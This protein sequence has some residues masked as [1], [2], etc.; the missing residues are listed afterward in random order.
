MRETCNAKHILDT[1]EN[2]DNREDF[3]IQKCNQ[4]MRS[5]R[6]IESHL[7]GNHGHSKAHKGAY[8]QASHRTDDDLHDPGEC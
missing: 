8:T 5:I 2:D 1:Y 6:V 7:P 3:P 4:L